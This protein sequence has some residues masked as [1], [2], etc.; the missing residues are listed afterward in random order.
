[1]PLST[2]AWSLAGSQ[3]RPY[4]PPSDN[5]TRGSSRNVKAGSKPVVVIVFGA[6]GVRM[7]VSSG[8]TGSFA[9]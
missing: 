9:G 2:P 7:Y 1:M 5:P 4:A 3:A 8:L 6:Q